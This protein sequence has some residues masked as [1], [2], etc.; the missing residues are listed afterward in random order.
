MKVESCLQV[1]HVVVTSHNRENSKSLAKGLQDH[2]LTFPG[3]H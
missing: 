1:A 2:V 3:L